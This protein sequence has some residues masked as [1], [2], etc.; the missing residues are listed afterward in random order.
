MCV[1]E[2]MVLSLTLVLLCDVVTCGDGVGGC[3]V[4]CVVMVGMIL[5]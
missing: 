2:L 1:C 5:L 4:W 3:V